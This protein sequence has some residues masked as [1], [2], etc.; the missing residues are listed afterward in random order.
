VYSDIVKILL[1]HNFYQQPGGEDRVFED[2]GGLLEG[3]GHAVLRYT[4][5]NRAIRGRGAGLACR[6]IWNHDT[7]RAVLR[8]LRVERPDVVHCHNIFPLLSPSLYY[9]AARQ[10]VPVVQTLHNY[11]LLCPGGFFLKDDHLCEVCSTR[12]LAWP[13]VRKR[14][15]RG[16]L[17]ATSVAAATIAV[18]RAW[19]T[20][21]N[22]VSLY[23]APSAFCRNKFIEAGFPEGDI[24]VKTNFVRATCKPPSAPGDYVLFVGRLSREKGIETLLQAWSASEGRLP[25]KIAGDGPLKDFV[26]ERARSNSHVHFLGKVDAAE[27]A[28]LMRGA[29]CLVVPS[30]WYEVSSRVAIEAYAAGTPVIGSRLGALEEIVAGA[31]GG[32]GFEAGNVAELRSCIERL[33]QMDDSGLL[34]LRSGARAEYEAKYTPEL[35]Y[36]A[37]MALYRQALERTPVP[38]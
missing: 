24:V 3:Q 27:V 38:A 35:N 2:E 33:C 4:A 12:L 9:A 32:V 30:L 7:Y 19:G 13:A 5:D 37:L 16:S 28:R 25:L 29:R 10:G 18:H 11:R 15:Y 6:T 8:L 21:R 34:A 22:C 26:L 23:C 20:W 31:P 17:A 14:C 1:C 36:T